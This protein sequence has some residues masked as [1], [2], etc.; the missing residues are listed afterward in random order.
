MT[1]T[2]APFRKKFRAAAIACTFASAVLTGYFASQQSP[3]WRI[4]TACVVALVVISFASD[5]AILFVKD[6][7]R[8]G[9]RTTFLLR[10]GG[11]ALVFAVNLMSNLGAVGW[12]RDVTNS[13]ARM[14]NTLHDDGRDTV[15]K[16]KERVEWFDARGKELDANLKKLT[17]TRVGSFVVTVAPSSPADLQG[18]IDA[19]NTEIANETARG[20]CKTRCEDRK[21]ELGHLIALQGLAK[22][23]EENHRQHAA[24]MEGLA[25]AK[26]ESNEATAVVSAPASQASFFASLFKASLTPSEDAKIWTDRGIAMLLAI[27]LCIAPIFFADMGWDNKPNRREQD[28]EPHHPAPSSHPVKRPSDILATFQSAYASACKARGVRPIEVA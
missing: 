6:A 12:Q 28:D 8:N 25:K 11:F 13:Q 14:Q 27:A 7:A 22:S 20:G 21:K 15:T 19:K 16:I 10:C 2:L 3:D 24:A 23:I 5:Y 4:A 18:Q 9:G 1:D 17:E 26:T